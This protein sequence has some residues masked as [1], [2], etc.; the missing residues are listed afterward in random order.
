VSVCDVMHI[1]LNFEK[2]YIHAHSL[3]MDSDLSNTQSVVISLRDNDDSD[4]D[5]GDS[6]GEDGDG[7]SDGEDED[8]DS[9]GDDSDAD[10]DDDEEAP[11]I[12]FNVD[13]ANSWWEQVDLETNA[14][15][16]DVGVDDWLILTC[17]GYIRMQNAWGTMTLGSCGSDMIDG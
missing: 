4:G 2:T 1:D 6:D 11:F 15:I 17:P 14:H 10:G 16:L 13:M 9:D 5:D 12:E 7:D 8:S 3:A